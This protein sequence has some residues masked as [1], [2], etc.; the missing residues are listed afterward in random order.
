MGTSASSKGPEAGVAFDPPWLND[1][2]GFEPNEPPPKSVDSPPKLEKDVAPVAQPA[3]APPARFQQARTCMSKYASEK[4]GRV[5]FQK[6][7]GHYSKTGMGGAGK[8]AHRMRHSTATGAKLAH[9]L[10][11]TSSRQD[12]AVEAWVKDII[13]RKLTGQDL[14][15]A[16]VQQVAPSAGSR[17]EE[18]CADSMARALSEFLEKNPDAEIL[19]LEEAHVR[20]IT[21]RFLANE[22]CN[23]L[24]NDVGQI[25]ESG[26]ISLKE[27]LSLLNEMREYLRA[28][29]SLQIADLWKAAANPSQSE[30]DRVLR[31]A[32]QRTFEVY[33]GEI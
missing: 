8:L 21:E 14:I 11:S 19:S 4:S 24:T 28:D 16:I 7:A 5:G 10:T 29:L 32:V 17:E 30:L 9:F 20:E 1:N 25:L 12:A 23:R 3:L 26:K 33:E 13:D 6:A 27:S 15:D 18:S 2:G 22:A 31:T